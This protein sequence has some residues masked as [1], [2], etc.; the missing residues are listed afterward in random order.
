MY[1]LDWQWNRYVLGLLLSWGLLGCPTSGP[2]P[3]SQ[4]VTP[5]RA[6]GKEIVRVEHDKPNGAIQ[7]LV[8]ALLQ[9]Q[10][11]ANFGYFVYLIFAEQTLGTYNARLAAAESFKC[12]RAPLSNAADLGL[13]KSDLAVFYAP[14]KKNTKVSR[15]VRLGSAP[16]I[17]KE[18]RYAGANFLLRQLK[19]RNTST[20]GRFDFTIGLVGSPVPLM[21]GMA[22]VDVDEVQVLKLDR[23]SPHQIT[24]IIRKFKKGLT[25]KK[26][27]DSGKVVN[28]E[29]DL[30]TRAK[31][32][33]SKAAAGVFPARPESENEP[34]TCR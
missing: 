5:Q 29:T 7:L 1:T 34:D 26:E 4:A 32:T 2:P 11:D 16:S 27:D 13:R 12:Q 31:N 15:L 23:K 22:G 18:Y 17:L 9:D 33:F 28:A 14:V 21:T 8:R 24:M 6:I 10:E 30:G 3:G 20:V 25:T 19:V